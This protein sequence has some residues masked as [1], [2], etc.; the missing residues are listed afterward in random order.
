M[1][2]SHQFSSTCSTEFFVGSFIHIQGYHS[3]YLSLLDTFFICVHP[4]H[5]KTH[6]PATIYE[7]YFKFRTCFTKRSSREYAI[8]YRPGL[9]SLLEDHTDLLLTFLTISCGLYTTMFF[10][11]CC[12]LFF[13]SSRTDSLVYVGTFVE[14]TAIWYSRFHS[15]N[16]ARSKTII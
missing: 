12:S 9:K 6:G 14:G 2:T 7:C 13:V 4:V 10:C 16:T 1:T 5:I 3:L 8:L 11:A 15:M